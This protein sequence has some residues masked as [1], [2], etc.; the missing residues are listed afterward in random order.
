MNNIDVTDV[1]DRSRLHPLQILVVTL[2]GI[3]MIMDGF[4]V[5]AMGY[6][7][8]ALIKEWQIQPT[9]LG[10]IFGAG[11]LGIMV[12][13]LALSI[14]ADKIGRRPVLIGPDRLICNRRGTR[15]GLT[16]LAASNR[17]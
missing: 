8:P 7:A 15:R 1:I 16:V 11:L 4:D 3:C 9:A 17:D 14:V 10:P 5:Q 6:V 13:S 12:G 2:C